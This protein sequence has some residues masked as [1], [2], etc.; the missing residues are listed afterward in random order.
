MS[1]GEASYLQMSSSSV[2]IV[3]GTVVLYALKEG[4]HHPKWTKDAEIGAVPVFFMF[5]VITVVF[6]SHVIVIENVVFDVF[7]LNTQPQETN[8]FG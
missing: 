8:R 1:G 4:A 7:L 3:V 5:V 2:V 6:T